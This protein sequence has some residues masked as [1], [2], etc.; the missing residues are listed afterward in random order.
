MVMGVW[1]R[2]DL[3]LPNVTIFFA[4]VAKLI[5]DFGLVYHSLPGLHSGSNPATGHLYQHLPAGEGDRVID[6]HIV[7]GG[8]HPASWATVIRVDNVENRENTR[9]ESERWVV[10][11]EK[12]ILKSSGRSACKK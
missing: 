12:K 7:A 10:G 5:G 4:G 3:V 6:S 11:I 8:L 2:T 1:S 9:G